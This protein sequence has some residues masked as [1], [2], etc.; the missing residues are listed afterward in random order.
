MR[1]TI[2]GGSLAGSKFALRG[3]VSAKDEVIRAHVEH[4][5][6]LKEAVARAEERAQAAQDAVEAMRQAD[7]DRRAGGRLAR[8]KA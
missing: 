8:L 6:S 1:L 4:I 5:A 2:T 3:C 7:A